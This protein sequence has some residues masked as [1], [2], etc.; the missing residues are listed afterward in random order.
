MDSSKA[1]AT[2]QTETRI[3]VIGAGAGRTGTTSFK[4]ALELLGYD[5]CYHMQDNAKLGHSDF[6]SRAL[7]GEPYDFEEVFGPQNYKASCDY[8]SSLFWEEQLLRYPEAKV[9]L[10]Y[11]DPEK[12]YKSC[13]DTI[14]KTCPDSPFS[15]LGI[16]TMLFLGLASKGF[17]PMLSKLYRTI[18]K[19]SWKKEDIIRC[20][21]EY[22]EGVKN[23]CPPGK[24][25]VFE[26]SQGWEPLCQFLD[27]PIPSVPFPCVND[28]AEFNQFVSKMS[29]VGYVVGTAC[30]GIPFLLLPAVSPENIDEIEKVKNE[31][32]RTN[33]SVAPGTLSS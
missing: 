23:R 24:L 33:V 29:T 8:P 11:R 7:D 10:T 5:P 28:S 20:Y 9:V 15:N 21:N 16:R 17:G 26:V 31:S 1:L 14:F 6:W 12:W 13:C 27:K 25:L 3:E 19:N 18:T 22:V 2:T 32:A 4:K 30:L